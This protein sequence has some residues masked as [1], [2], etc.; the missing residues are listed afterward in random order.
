MVDAGLRAARWF[1]RLDQEY[2]EGETSLLIG[3]AGSATATALRWPEQHKGYGR[4][5]ERR[6]D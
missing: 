3:V 4:Q 2:E 5:A 1:V 6:S